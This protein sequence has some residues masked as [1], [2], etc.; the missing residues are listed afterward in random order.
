MNALSHVAIIMDG[1]GRWATEKKKPR[2]Y[3]HL[4]GTKNIKNFIPYCK[5]KKIP[6][7]TLFAFG[8]DN[9]RR[10]KKEISYLFFLF[11]DFLRKNTQYLLENN[12]KIKFI[13]EK[14]KLSKNLISAIQ[15]I[16][17]ITKKNTELTIIVA[18]NYSSKEELINAFREILKQK[19]QKKITEKTVKKYLYTSNIPD[20]D[21]LIRTGSNK[22]LSNFLLWQLSYTELFFIKK[23]WP[24]FGTKD[25]SSVIKSYKKIKRNF[26][27]I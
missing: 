24:D 9:W 23:F 13:G 20:P 22:R 27:K 8:L 21:I 3:G 16:E 26:G 2:N 18:F 10:P 1:N 17:K 5:K 25:L 14:K 4:E 12:V 6:Y 11:Q 19:K 15:K 7:L